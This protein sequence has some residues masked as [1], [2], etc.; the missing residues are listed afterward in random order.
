[1]NGMPIASVHV[2]VGT[3]SGTRPSIRT[4]R[5]ATPSFGVSSNRTGRF[6]RLIDS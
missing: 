6:L 4:A 1:M 2:S 3:G 5:P